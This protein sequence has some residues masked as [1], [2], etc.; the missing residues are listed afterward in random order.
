M[1]NKV[2]KREQQ[3]F[4][5]GLLA[6]IIFLV[7]FG[8]VM[9]YS[10][11]SYSALEKFNN[12]SYFFNKQVKAAVIGF[13]G[14]MIV[15]VFPVKLY[16]KLSKL[17]YFA[18]FFIMAL[19][20][21]PIGVEAY[22]A[23]R[24]I[25]IPLF[26]TMQPA[27]LTKLAVIIFIPV[28]ICK[29][30]KRI[31]EPKEFFTI[32]AWGGAAAAG[33]LFITDNLSSAVIVMGIVC[34][35]VFVAHP[36]TA[37]FI[38]IVGAGGA[39]VL[40][41][42]RILDKMMETSSDF[43]LRRILVWLHPEE[44]ASEGG[45]Q[46]MQGLYAIGSGGFFGKGLGNSAQKMVIPEVQNDMILSIICE[47]LGV[48][49]AIVLFTLFGMLLYRLMF[50]AQ[51]APDMYSSLIVTGIFGH[52]ALQV[53]LNVCV[54]LNVIPTTGISLPFISYGGT[55]LVISMA[56]L[57]IALGISRKISLDEPEEVQKIKN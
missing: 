36:R 15:S 17:A 16:A 25:S 13:I 34:I 55:A 8:L 7:S 12:S 26:G 20:W 47:E 11:S 1:S 5:Y 23:R 22:G 41:G 52:I 30:G 49:G 40:V 28:L 3:Y 50:I 9:L 6:I 19:V 38:G 46:T 32:L 4:D 42:V 31:R 33:V 54:V 27:E 29:V 24:W 48:C 37:P 53:I 57:G 56:E 39:A 2:K 43:R 18:S 21:T 14:M 44:Y 51:N 35:M 10:T 45:F